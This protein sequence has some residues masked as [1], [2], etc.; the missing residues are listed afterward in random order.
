VVAQRQIL[1]ECFATGINPTPLRRGP[2]H[3][4]VLLSQRELEILAVDFTGAGE[5][6][7]LVP[8]ARQLQKPLGRRDMG[9]NRALR[10]LQHQ[11][12]PHHRREVINLVRAHHQFFEPRR[13][14]DGVDNDF[15]V[16]IAP[17]LFQVGE[18]TGRQIIEDQDAATL[19]Q[20]RLNQM[21]AD[22]S[23]TACN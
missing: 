14:R 6:Q 23:C 9:G 11:T 18:R 10:F 8:G 13:I 12:H 7:R 1:I 17:H 4:V 15:E 21:A 22:E 16:R 2:E 5:E 19:A 3:E 20:Q